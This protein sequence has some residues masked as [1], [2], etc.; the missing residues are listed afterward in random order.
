[1]TIPAQPTTTA[2]PTPPTRSDPG[3][4]AARGDTFL[5]WLPTGWAYLAA[6][7][8]WIFDRAQDVF[9]WASAA[10]S[11]RMLVQTAAAAVAAANP[12]INAAAAAASATAAGAYATLAQATNPDSPVRLNPRNISTNL[13]IPSN[14]NAQ[15]SG[16]IVI[17]EGVSV[18]VSE[19]AS[20]SIV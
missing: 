1:M 19:N 13:V 17:G 12:V 5:S 6:A 8:A 9:S 14:Y 15:S 20:W 3:S 4:F 7:M 18:T 2:V 16:P 11:D 10:Q